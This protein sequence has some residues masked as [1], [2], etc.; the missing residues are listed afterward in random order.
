MFVFMGI[1]VALTKHGE[2]GVSPYSVV[3]PFSV[4]DHFF[5]Y[6]HYSFR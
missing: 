5:L 4:P 1:G 3:M 2:S 6:F